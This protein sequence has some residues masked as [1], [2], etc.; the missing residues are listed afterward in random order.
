M[1]NYKFGYGQ[2]F[3]AI[4]LMLALAT[5]ATAQSAIVQTARGR[6][7]ELVEAPSKNIWCVYQDNNDHYWFGSDGEGVYRLDSQSLVRFSKNDGLRNDRIREIQQDKS[8][9]I[10]FTT[11]E[12]IS[13]FDGEKFVNLDAQQVQVGDKGWRLQTGDLWFRGPG[14]NGPF[15]TTAKTCMICDSP[16]KRWRTIL[17][18]IGLMLYSMPMRFTQFTPIAAEVFGWAQR[19]LAFAALTASSSIGCMKNN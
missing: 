18:P 11:L 19:I 3:V 10:L 7:G 9:N 6:L 8:G 1:K 15:D 2:F 5:C 12:G 16:S 13:K 4:C 17:L 14:K